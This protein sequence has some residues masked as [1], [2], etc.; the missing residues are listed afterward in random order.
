MA[1]TVMPSAMTKITPRDDDPRVGALIP[2]APLVVPEDGLDLEPGALELPRHLWHRQ[3]SEDQLEAMMTRAPAAPLDV[4]LLECGQALPAILPHGFDQ[5]EIGAGRP[6]PQLH[7]VGVLTPFRHI[8]DEIDP[9]QTRR[10]DDAR[11]RCE[12]SREVA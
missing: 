6:S 1:P 5:R 2:R 4:A 7:F 9:E 3:R 12:R 10:L 8:G 11:D